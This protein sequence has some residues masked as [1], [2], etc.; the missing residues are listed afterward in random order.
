MDT[1]V[2]DGDD[3]ENGNDD[4]PAN[5]QHQLI[6]KTSIHALPEVVFEYILSQ[7]SPYNDHL[8]CRLVSKAWNEGIKCKSI[9]SIQNGY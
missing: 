7:V 8:A 5:N 3:D 9:L 2:H 1:K 4:D 6:L